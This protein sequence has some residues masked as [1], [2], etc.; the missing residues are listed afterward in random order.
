MLYFVPQSVEDLP[1]VPDP[2][3]LIGCRYPVG[4]CVFGIPEDGVGKPDQ[5]NH[6][7]VWRRRKGKREMTIGS[8]NTHIQQVC[9]LCCID[10]TF[11]W[12]STFRGRRIGLG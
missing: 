1:V 5:P 3:Q 8:F 9:F 7:A 10:G 6:V 2:Q 11:F 12:S 4:V